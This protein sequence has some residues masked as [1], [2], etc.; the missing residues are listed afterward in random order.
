MKRSPVQIN[1]S[2]VEIAVQS[3]DKYQRSV[4]TVLCDDGT[5]WLG[6]QGDKFAWRQLPEIPQPAESEEPSVNNELFEAIKSLI[7][8]RQ[9]C[10][11]HDDT[12][13]FAFGNGTSNFWET[14]RRSVENSSNS[15]TT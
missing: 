12:Y 10:S 7:A 4:I 15:D 9:K 14:L 13:I 8:A 2:T 6:E 11:N 3:G 1:T 5:L